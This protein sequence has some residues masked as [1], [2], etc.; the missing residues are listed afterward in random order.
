MKKYQA[1]AASSAELQ[2]KLERLK[3]KPVALTF[4]ETE[5]LIKV[6]KARN[7]TSGAQGDYVLN[8]S[9]EQCRFLDPNFPDA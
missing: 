6:V 2:S 7:K 5:T 3:R 4:S 9:K 8:Y 1:A